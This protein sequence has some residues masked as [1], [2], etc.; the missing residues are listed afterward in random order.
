MRHQS[1]LT[2]YARAVGLSLATPWAERECGEQMAYGVRDGRVFTTSN[3]IV[4]HGQVAQTQK[5]RQTA[6]RGK[7]LTLVNP[8]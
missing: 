8:S 6:P 4:T 3:R 5:I 2:Y 7:L 1:R